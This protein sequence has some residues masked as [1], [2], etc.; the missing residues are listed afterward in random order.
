MEE[1]FIIRMD[2][3]DEFKENSYYTCVSDS[4]YDCLCALASIEREAAE[5]RISLHGCLFTIKGVKGTFRFDDYA[6]CEWLH[7]G[8]CDEFLN[9]CRVLE[10]VEQ[11]VEDILK[12]L[13][14]GYRFKRMPMSGEENE[15]VGFMCEYPYPISCFGMKFNFAM[16]V[17]VRTH[18]DGTKGIEYG[19]FEDLYDW[20]TRKDVCIKNIMEKSG[21]NERDADKAWNAIADLIDLNVEAMHDI[22]GPEFEQ[23]LPDVYIVDRGYYSGYLVAS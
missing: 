10:S 11:R 14:C 13:E 21:M 6:W 17:S 9:E 1:K 18:K 22:F 19:C 15:E 2:L 5:K 7:D 8:G 3:P 20:D 12:S 4:I 23:R 16:V